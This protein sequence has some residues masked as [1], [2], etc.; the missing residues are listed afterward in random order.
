MWCLTSRDSLEVL[1]ADNVGC[2]EATSIRI[3]AFVMRCGVADS[4]G[5][6]VVVDSEALSALAAQ[7]QRVRDRAAVRTFIVIGLAPFV[8]IV[9]VIQLHLW[10]IDFWQV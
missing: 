2:E 3:C 6:P 8:S 10:W 1:A 5:C 4:A 9:L 7:D